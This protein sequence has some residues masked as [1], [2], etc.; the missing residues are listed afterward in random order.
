MFVLSCCSL[1]DGNM[2]LLFLSIFIFTARSVIIF[3]WKIYKNGVNLFSNPY[4][5]IFYFFWIFVTCFWCSYGY[6]WIQFLESSALN[7]V[8]KRIIFIT[9]LERRYW[10]YRYLFVCSG[11]E[12]KTLCWVMSPVPLAKI[13]VT[14]S[15]LSPPRLVYIYFP[16]LTRRMLCSSG[17]LWFNLKKSPTQLLHQD[18]AYHLSLLDLFLLYSCQILLGTLVDSANSYH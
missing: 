8:F 3:V 15:S 14:S 11:S 4:E 18:I 5:T 6:K 10:T 17:N 13:S 2:F 9:K 12:Q 7:R 16:N 1:Y